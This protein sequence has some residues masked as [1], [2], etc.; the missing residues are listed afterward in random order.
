VSISNPINSR[1]G[2]ASKFD[3]A[4]WAPFAIFFV[5]AFAAPTVLTPARMIEGGTCAAYALFGI[6]LC[7]IFSYTGYPSLAQAGL[8]AAAAYGMAVLVKDGVFGPEVA[9]LIVIVGVALLTLLIGVAMLTLQ[10]FYFAMTTLLLGSI[11]TVLIGTIFAN[12]TGGFQGLPVTPPRGLGLNLADFHDRYYVGWGL[13]AF[14]V[15]FMGNIER[16]KVVRRARAVKGD[17]LVGRLNG[18]SPMWIKL[19]MFVLS[20][21]LI[22]IASLLL[23]FSTQYVTSDVF[24]LSLTVTIFAGL[25]V[26]GRSNVWGAV[27]GALFVIVVNEL[28]RSISLLN[29]FQTR[30][31]LIYGVVMA[32]VLLWSPGGLIDLPRLIRLRRRKPAPD[33]DLRTLQ[34]FGARWD[35][36]VKQLDTSAVPSDDTAPP[37][38][39]VHD[40]T[41]DFSG[42]TAVSAASFQIREG[43]ILGIMGPNGAGKTTLLNAISGNV[44]PTG[45]S[46]TLGGQEIVGRSIQGIRRAGVARTLQTPHVFDDMTVWENIALGTDF[47]HRVGLIEAGLTLPRSR[48]AEKAAR[49]EAEGLAEIVGLTKFARRMGGEL[50]F[51]QRRLVEIARALGGQSKLLLLDE[52]MAGLSPAMADVVQT[53]I[54]ECR[55]RGYS[56]ALIEHNFDHVEALADH[57]IFMLGGMVAKRGTIRE[58]LND[59]EV[60]EEYVGA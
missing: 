4:R 22:S 12:Q 54:L 10:G 31:S 9:S 34:P 55:T 19:Q 41:V 39:A 16:T 40:L 29:Q 24:D 25:V 20:G 2:V 52:P 37:L 13:V 48:R 17:E 47:C 14:F 58:L 23:V 15:A 33:E 57:G 43:E 46:I 11:A 21:I 7:A 5:L 1:H 60:I 56:V 51:G 26:G 27:A 44:R 42:F 35:A 50:S 18:I 49:L 30:A 6:G 28:L 8:G 59:R 38:L 45:G 3:I 36:A 32:A 53:L